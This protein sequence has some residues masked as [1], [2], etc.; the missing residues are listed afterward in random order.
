MKSKAYPY[1]RYS[2]AGQASGDSERRQEEKAIEF[3]TRHNLDYDDSY[4]FH[5]FAVSGYKGDNFKTGGKLKEYIDLV[6]DGTIEKNTY[7]V[8]ENID[9]FSRLTPYEAIEHFLKLVKIGIKIAVVDKNEIHQGDSAA[10]FIMSVLMSME[11][12]HEESKKKGERVQR[13][14]NSAKQDVINGIRPTLWKWGTPKWL[15]ITPNSYTII[16]DREETIKRILAWVIEGH[17]TSAIIERLTEQGIDPWTSSNIKVKKRPTTKWYNSQISRIVNNRALIGELEL[18]IKDDSGNNARIEIIPNF[19]PIIISED[20]FIQVQTARRS[21]KS[22]ADSKNMA[23]GSGGRIGKIVSNL[24]QKLAVCG[25]S[26]EDNASGHKCPDNSRFMVYANKDKKIAGKQYRGRYLQCGA[27]REKGSPCNDCNK[28][29]RYEHLETAFL[30]HVKDVSVATIFGSDDETKTKVTIINENI[31]VLNDQLKNA[32]KKVIEYAAALEKYG[33]SGTLLVLLNK[34]EILQR[35]IPNQIT[36]LKSQRKQLQSTFE[37]GKQSKYQLIDLIELMSSCEDD[38]QLFELRFKISTLLKKMIERIEVYNRGTFINENTIARKIA[39]LRESTDHFSETDIEE[40]VKVVRQSDTEL[41]KQKETPFFV[42][43]Y[44]S[45]E[46]RI[47]KHALSD[48]TDLY[49]NMKYNGDGLTE[50]PYL[51]GME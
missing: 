35:N 4:K 2:S 31:E 32:D 40:M 8:I 9:R 36:E 18:I 46:S 41:A 38:T 21:R 26:I 42:V 48:P 23:R 34:S 51:K 13:A 15:K 6:E 27:S 25:Y 12:A 33:T 37:H 30:T 50:Q 19:F 44:K 5:D 29:Y 17:G 1:F 47:I 28:M 45:G 22:S 14:K 49:L 16:P 10:I 7:L 39:R 3:C 20:Y 11:M 43:K 24:F